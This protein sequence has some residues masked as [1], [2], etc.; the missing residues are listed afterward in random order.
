MPSNCTDPG[1]KDHLLL[2]LTD[3]Q[4]TL[5]GKQI[6]EVS[7]QLTKQAH[8]LLLCHL[9]KFQSRLHS[10]CKIGQQYH[11]VGLIQSR[12]WSLSRWKCWRATISMPKRIDLQIL[13]FRFWKQYGHYSKWQAKSMNMLIT[14]N[15]ANDSESHQITNC[16]WSYVLYATGPVYVHANCCHIAMII[17]QGRQL[18]QKIM[19]FSIWHAESSC[20]SRYTN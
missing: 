2:N 10:H 16:K 18:A 6:P 11:M 17:L 14:R 7:V 8:L 15:A 20:K 19:M 13:S 12:A 9:K 3:I 5:E 4:V 1:R